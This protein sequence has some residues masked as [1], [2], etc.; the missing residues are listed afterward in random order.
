MI[1]LQDVAKTHHRGETA[2]HALRGV[3]ATIPEG[4]FTFILGP[5]GSG[6]STLLYLMGALDAPTAGDIV[7]DG[8]SINEMPD[9][10]KD[11]YRRDDVGFI[12][13]SFNLLKN[14]NAV[15]NALVPYL[16]RGVNGE[17]KSRAVELLK[18]VGL[19]NRIDHTPNQLSGGEQQRVAIA[20]ALLKDPKLILADE[21]TGELDSKTGAE[22][23]GYLR[24]LHAE[25]KST[26]VVVTHDQSHLTSGDTVL[27]M[28]DGR[29][30]E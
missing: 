12:F 15:D 24:D 27:R 1:E 10:A 7:V 22:V 13:Q 25:R 16:P 14:L 11:S 21:P 30:E 2:V 20:R 5:S 9:S 26:V 6:K 29:I 8:H 19:E 18:R 28:R 4:S 3:T 17:L 23:F